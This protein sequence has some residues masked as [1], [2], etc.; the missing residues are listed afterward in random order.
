MDDI[1]PRYREATEEPIV[2]TAHVLAAIAAATARDGQVDSGLFRRAFQRVRAQPIEARI[3]S[4]LK[5]NVDIRVYITD[6]AGIVIYDSDSGRD[7][8]VNYSEWNDVHHTLRGH[9][10]ART[11]PSRADPKTKVLYVASPIVLDGEIIGVLSVGKSA[12]NSNRFVESARRDLMLG[13]AAVCVVLIIAGVILGQWLTRPIRRLTDYAL[14]IRD[15]RRAELPRLPPGELRDLGA[16]FEQMRTAL[17]GKRY[18]ENYVQTLTHEIKS[19]LSAIRGAAELLGEDLPTDQRRQFI[20]N[21][22]SESERITHIAETLMLLTSLE[23]SGAVKST[24]PIALD[25]IALDAA[26]SLGILIE[27]RDLTIDD[28]G[29]EPVTVYGDGVLIRQAIVNLLQNAVEFSPPQTVIS[30]CTRIIDDTVV[31]EVRDHGPGIPDYAESKIYDRFFSLTR[32][33]SGKKSS[34]LGLSLVKEI[35]TLHEGSVV[36]ASHPEGGTLATLVFLHG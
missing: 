11:S 12:T 25:R 28:S 31:F 33:D 24:G 1:Q 21:I 15:G 19:P 3:Y 8:G 16:A 32:P 34:G 27:R 20:D 13:G 14:A 7:E 17:E 18:V 4:F 6:A 2:D 29:I 30:I 26:A 36:V 10:G 9:Y 23:S 35:M 22:S 5:T